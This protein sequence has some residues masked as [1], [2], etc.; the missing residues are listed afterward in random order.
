M[1]RKQLP[2]I[3]SLKAKQKIAMLTA[4]TAPFARVLDKHADILLVGDSLGMVLYGM[5]STLP[6]TLEMMAQHGR[7]VVK[8]SE[9]A[10]VV[11]D[12]PLAATRNHASR[13]LNQRL[14]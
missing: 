8:A 12:M 5:D 4:Y 7:A 2:D 10:M 6:V 9:Q 14:T 13:R 11:V 1:T 3:Q